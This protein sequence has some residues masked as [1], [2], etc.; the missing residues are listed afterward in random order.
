MIKR[1]SKSQVFV[2]FESE[3]LLPS[4]DV[5]SEHLLEF[6]FLFCV[7]LLLDSLYN[8]LFYCLGLGLG[9][10]YWPRGV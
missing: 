2:S 3:R 1:K 6:E 9:C 4:I 10:S 8:F 5:L 7:S